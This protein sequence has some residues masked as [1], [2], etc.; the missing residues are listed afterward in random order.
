MRR[1]RAIHF[2]RKGLGAS[3]SAFPSVC[4]VAARRM[5]FWIAP[6][7]PNA[8][9]GHFF[10]RLTST[11]DNIPF[12]TCFRL[13]LSDISM[14]LSR[15]S[16]A[17]VRDSQIWRRIHSHACRL[18]KLSAFAVCRHPSPPLVECYKLRA[19]KDDPQ[20]VLAV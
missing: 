14:Q 15:S 9:G 16:L 2:R 20:S 17:S 5:P 18:K 10:C 7:F 13:G 12:L 3:K 1:N 4:S 8:L 11:G 19:R 6:S